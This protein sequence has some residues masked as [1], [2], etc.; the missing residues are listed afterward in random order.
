MILVINS[1]SSSLKFKLFSPALKELAGGIVE[2]V[3]LK[4]SF[5]SSAAGG[6]SFRQDFPGGVGDHKEALRVVFDF[7]KSNGFDAADVSAVGHR[8]VHGGEEF[9]SPTVVSLSVFKRLESYNRLAPLHNPANLAGIAAVAE[10]LPKAK[11][12]AVF[13]TAFYRTLP[14]YAYMYAI[15]WKCYSEHKIRKYGFHG[16]SHE[17]V[18]RE[19]ARLLEKPY[20]KL[21]LVSCHLG[22]G[23]SVTAV[24]FGKAVET[25]MGFTPLEGLTMSTRCGD[26][27][28]AIP[29]YLMRTL[30]LTEQQVDDMLNKESGL[31]GICGYKD[32]RDVL[33]AAG[34]KVSG[35]DFKDKV[36]PEVGRRAKLAFE[37]FC[38]DVARYIGSYAAVMGGC[39][40]VVFT[41]GVG[42]RSATVRGKVMSMLKLAGRPKVLVV[43]TN[44]ELLIAREAKALVK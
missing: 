17:Y 14:D 44:E 30:S 24:K 25:S 27:D 7:L 1:G 3:G 5:L 42:E 29:L 10:L 41:A 23:S 38:Y 33:S 21:K 20:A 35:Y 28:P 26:I 8:V 22:S 2:R 12:V 34:V 31:L 9:V 4:D 6:R 40:A 32:L 36:T 16:I 43:P 15:P 11:N 19:A 13:D 37:M 39:D 18:T